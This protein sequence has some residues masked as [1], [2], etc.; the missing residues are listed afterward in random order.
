VGSATGGRGLR[1]RDE[2]QQ[3]VDC[4][5]SSEGD[6]EI[7]EEMGRRKS[8]EGIETQVERAVPE[9][10]RGGSGFGNGGVMSYPGEAESDSGTVEGMSLG[11][12]CLYRIADTAAGPRG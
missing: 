6:V 5:K 12:G 10:Q 11:R 2:R 4:G 7:A 3:G 1:A 8:V 9:E